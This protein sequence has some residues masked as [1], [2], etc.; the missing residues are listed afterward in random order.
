MH[1]RS[2]SFTHVGTVRD[3]NEDALVDR[4]EIGLFGVADG[5]GGHDSGEVASALLRENLQAIPAGLGPAEMV[6]RV[7]RAIT[8]AHA[9]LLDEARRRGPGT[10][11]ASTIVVLLLHGDHFACL[12]AGDSRLYLFGDG[13]LQ[14]LSRDHSLVQ[15]MVDAGI[16]RPEDAEGHPRANIITRA[17]GANDEP[18]EVDK[19][20]GHVQ[21]GDRFL[22]CS[23]GLFKALAETAVAEVLADPA[24]GG[25]PA[26]RLIE[27]ALARR[28]SDNVTAVVV[29][30]L[31]A[32]D[33]GPDPGPDT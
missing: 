25:S 33:G 22:L 13:R 26:E 14:Q 28:A 4:P 27:A 30:A 2:W 29:E 1:Y 21:P 20:T 16:L 5:A 6:G 32:P 18:L 19:V 15:E 3:H 9:A 12:W 8:D 7:R 10:V 17:V 23:D 24:P 31:A 11:I